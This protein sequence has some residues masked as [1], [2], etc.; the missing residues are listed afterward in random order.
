MCNED[1]HGYGHLSWKSLI[2]I[3]DRSV[4]WRFFFQVSSIVSLSYSPYIVDIKSPQAKVF[5]FFEA[6]SFSCSIYICRKPLSG[7]VH[8]WLYLKLSPTISF[9]IHTYFINQNLAFITIPILSS[10]R[11]T[12]IVT[13][14]SGSS[15]L[16]KRTP[17]F[18]FLWSLFSNYNSHVV[19]AFTVSP[20]REYLFDSFFAHYCSDST[21]RLVAYLMD[22]NLVT[23]CNFLRC[24]L[25]ILRW[26]LFFHFVAVDSCVVHGWGSYLFSLS[27]NYLTRCT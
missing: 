12:N 16:I 3:W 24:Y 9:S 8:F 5:Q 20:H 1:A 4:L 6:F 18:Y 22:L 14:F 2:F 13:K 11:M 17:F 25:I 15:V 26:L 27:K 23:P 21:S 19:F 10:L 7:C